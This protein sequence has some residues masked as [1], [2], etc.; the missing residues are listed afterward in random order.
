MSDKLMIAIKILTAWIL[1]AFLSFVPNWDPLNSGHPKT[2]AK[3][4]AF[5]RLPL[6][7][8]FPTSEKIFSFLPLPT[9]CH[10]RPTPLLGAVPKIAHLWS[11]PTRFWSYPA[12]FWSYP[13]RF[14]SYSNSFWSYPNTFCSYPSRFCPGFCGVLPLFWPGFAP[15][16]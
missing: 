13:T 15:I 16:L 3:P 10:L 12:R 9:T 7:N 11:Y 1:K 5:P 2:G 4:G 8:I 6:N 14:W